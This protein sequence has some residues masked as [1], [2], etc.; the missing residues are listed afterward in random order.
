MKGYTNPQLL[1]TPAELDAALK[2]HRK[3]LIIDLRPA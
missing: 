3:P 2:T 1:T